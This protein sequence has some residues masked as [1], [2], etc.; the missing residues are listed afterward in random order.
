MTE[1]ILIILFHTVEVLSTFCECGVNVEGLILVFEKLK[2][3]GVCQHW[4]L[5]FQIFE[6][7]LLPIIFV[8]VIIFLTLILIFF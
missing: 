5:I 7:D 1:M 6:N 4:F 2:V 8:I 3:L